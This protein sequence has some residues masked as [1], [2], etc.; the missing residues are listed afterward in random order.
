MHQYRA[1]SQLQSHGF[2]TGIHG[3]NHR[4]YFNASTARLH[5]PGLQYTAIPTAF[6]LHYHTIGQHHTG[7]P[8][9]SIAGIHC[10]AVDL[11]IS[12]AHKASNRALY[13]DLFII[14][15]EGVF[16]AALLH[17]TRGQDQ[18]VVQGP[19]NFHHHT[20]LQCITGNAA[21][22][23][24]GVIDDNLTQGK[25]ARCQ[26]RYHAFHFYLTDTGNKFPFL[27]D[28]GGSQL[29]CAIREPRD[30]DHITRHQGIETHSLEYSSRALGN[31][32]H[33]DH[34]H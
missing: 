6:G 15:S 25:L 34:G 17:H 20:V 3:G 31:H 18:A 11:E 23:C 9:G 29:P 24:V 1:T 19:V 26:Q 14:I 5:F 7:R 21:Q 13:T 16:D 2:G 10:H 32:F 8:Q 33:T 12:R 28:S 30:L 4:F 22:V 27:F